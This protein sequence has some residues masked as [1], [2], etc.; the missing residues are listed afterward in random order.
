MRYYEILLTGQMMVHRLVC[1]PDHLQPK[2]AKWL[3]SSVF[4]SFWSQASWSLRYIDLNVHPAGTSPASPSVVE[5]TFIV[6]AFPVHSMFYVR[7]CHDYVMIIKHPHALEVISYLDFNLRPFLNNSGPWRSTGDLD[8]LHLHIPWQV[9]VCVPTKVISQSMNYETIES[10]ETLLFVTILNMNMKQAQKTRTINDTHN[11]HN[12][13]FTYPA[14]TC[15]VLNSDVVVRGR[16]LTKAQWTT[17]TTASHVEKGLDSMLL[18]TVLMSSRI[19]WHWF[20]E[21][22]ST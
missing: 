13:H 16:V 19:G 15:H 5:Q 6:E 7:L 10:I 12:I 14:Y 4:K 1:W 20:A 11:S 21:G 22:I 9:C 2:R 8:T 17:W 18:K 3:K